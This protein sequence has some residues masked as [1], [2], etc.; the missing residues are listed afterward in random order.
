MFFVYWLPCGSYIV[1]LA[2]DERLF[3]YSGS[4]R[5]ADFTNN[6]DSSFIL[7][8]YVV[9]SSRPSDLIHILVTE[10]VSRPP[11]YQVTLCHSH[12]AED[13]CSEDRDSIPIW[14][15]ACVTSFQNGPI[16]R[17]I[18]LLSA[19]HAHMYL[20]FILTSFFPFV[21][22]VRVNWIFSHLHDQEKLEGLSVSTRCWGWGRSRYNL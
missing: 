1:M 19:K 3:F 10:N 13:I 7:S 6:Y 22:S 20:S 9:K 15:T 4:C 16:D 5:L 11:A 12:S 21:W 8:Q 2:F 14:K 17:M 18:F